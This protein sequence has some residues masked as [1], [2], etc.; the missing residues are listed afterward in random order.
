MKYAKVF[1]LLVISCL[2]FTCKP[3]LDLN[4]EDWNCKKIDD[5]RICVPTSW[6]FKEQTKYLFFTN[7]DNDDNNSYFVILKHNKTGSGLSI[8]KYLKEMYTV[9]RQK[10]TIELTRGYTLKKVI[11]DKA[12]TYHN[13][14]YSTISN[15]NYVTYTVI[16]EKDDNIFDMSLKIDE[17]HSTRYQELFRDVLF[18]F[19]YKNEP[20]FTPEEKINK[21][22]TIDL[23]KLK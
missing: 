11:S 15:K 19:Q 13:E 12:I 17:E 8:I 10:D 2:L 3:K 23:S 18:R 22:D 7:L 1:S 4:S 5:E 16:F 6:V 9:F 20:T 14:F 21:I